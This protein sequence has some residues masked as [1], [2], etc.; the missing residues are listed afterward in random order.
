MQPRAAKIWLQ[1]TQK[2]AAFDVSKRQLESEL[3]HH[4]YLNVISLDKMPHKIVDQIR[5]GCGLT[6]DHVHA[7]RPQSGVPNNDIKIT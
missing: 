5:Q 4:H 7:P 3:K 2:K 6:F 1:T